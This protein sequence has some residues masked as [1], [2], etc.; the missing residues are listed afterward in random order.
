[1]IYGKVLGIYCRFLAGFWDGEGCIWMPVGRGRTASTS[2]SQTKPEVLFKVKA[3]LESQGISFKMRSQTGKSKKAF[4]RNCIHYTLLLQG[5]RK[6]SAFLKKVFPYLE[7]DKKVYAP[8]I[9]RF[10]KMYPSLRK[11]RT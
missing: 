5:S 8:D 9:L 7:T 4:N 10:F 3:F 2:V 11:V 1:M 6:V